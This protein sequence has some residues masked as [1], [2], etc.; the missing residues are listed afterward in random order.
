M[1]LFH[2]HPVSPRKLALLC[3][4]VLLTTGLVSLSPPAGH[5]AGFVEEFTYY[6]DATFTHEVGFCITDTCTNFRHCSGQITNFYKI[7]VHPC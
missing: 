6:S 5:A 7:T 1:A 2:R 3:A 4:I